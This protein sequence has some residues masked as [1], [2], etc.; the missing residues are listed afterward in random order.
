MSERRVRQLRQ[1]YD[2]GKISPADY[3]AQLQ[4]LAARREA[5]PDTLTTAAER[6]LMRGIMSYEQ[7]CDWLFDE[8]NPTRPLMYVGEVCDDPQRAAASIYI[9]RACDPCIYR[10][11]DNGAERKANGRRKGPMRFRFTHNAHDDVDVLDVSMRPDKQY[12][13]PVW[14][15]IQK[16]I[17]T[18]LGVPRHDEY[19]RLNWS[20]TRGTLWITTPENTLRRTLEAKR[21]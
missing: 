9:A 17:Q 12:P 16:R 10:I 4:G 5:P 2:H 13:P 15:R 21:D 7:F 8:E 14:S 6:Q 1:D 20:I 19:R 3:L 11:K 18:I